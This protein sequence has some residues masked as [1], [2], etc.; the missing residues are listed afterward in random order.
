MG[1]SPAAAAPPDVG[2]RPTRPSTPAT[3]AGPALGAARGP[4]A[5]PEGGAAATAATAG[6]DATRADGGAADGVAISAVRSPAR[7]RAS[8]P[9]VIRYVAPCTRLRAAF[10]A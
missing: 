6:G 2:S 1:N 4:T 5:G 8:I 7:S 3:A 9:T 10:S